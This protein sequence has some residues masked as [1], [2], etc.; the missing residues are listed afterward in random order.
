MNYGMPWAEAQPLAKKRTPKGSGFAV[1]EAVAG[2]PDGP[3][4]G[5]LDVGVCSDEPVGIALCEVGSKA[6]LDETVHDE[7][8]VNK[9]AGVEDGENAGDDGCRSWAEAGHGSD[10]VNVEVSPRCS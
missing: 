3:A 6:A 2:S 4:R 10:E 7:G 5:V 9:S 1:S 8:A